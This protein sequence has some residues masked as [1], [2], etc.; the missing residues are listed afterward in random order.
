MWTF[1]GKRLVVPDGML[2]IQGGMFV[3]RRELFDIL[4]ETFA[5][6]YDS[7]EISGEMVDIAGEGFGYVGQKVATAI[8]PM[9]CRVFPLVV[10]PLLSPTCASQNSRLLNQISNELFRVFFVTILMTCSH[11]RLHSHPNDMHRNVISLKP[12]KIRPQH[13]RIEPG[14]RSSTGVE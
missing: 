8:S 4:A 1:V 7:S 5:H 6:S 9:V 3:I 2:D 12:H 14:C 10:F 11:I 13:G